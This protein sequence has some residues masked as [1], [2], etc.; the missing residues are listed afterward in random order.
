MRTMMSMMT[1]MISRFAKQT[2][3]CFTLVKN[4]KY[5]SPVVRRLR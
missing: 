2:T 5:I 1:M 4:M 3:E